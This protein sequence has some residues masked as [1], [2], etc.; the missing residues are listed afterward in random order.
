MK[1]YEL[2]W[3]RPEDKETKVKWEKVGILIEKEKGVMSVRLDFI[4]VSKEWDGWLTV[5]KP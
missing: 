1:I 5:V 2:L 3:K 4:P